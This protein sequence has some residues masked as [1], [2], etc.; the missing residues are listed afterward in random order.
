MTSPAFF[1]PSDTRHEPFVG[2]VRGGPR[3]LLRLEGAVALAAALAA[4]AHLGGS[5]GWFAAL[6]LVPDLSMLGYLAGPRLGAASYNAAHSYVGPALLALASLAL[7]APSLLLGVALWAA[8]VG[9]DRLLG[10]GLKYATA[11][12]DTHLGRVGAKPS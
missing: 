2:G 4:Y 10:Y 6:F 7:S 12:G 8:H 1:S 3:L 9:F 11:F 5:W